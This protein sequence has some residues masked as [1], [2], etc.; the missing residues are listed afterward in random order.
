[1]ESKLVSLPQEMARREKIEKSAGVDGTTSLA[2]QIFQG[3]AAVFEHEEIVTFRYVTPEWNVSHD[4][5]AELFGVTRELFGRSHIPNFNTEV[6]RKYLLK[7]RNAHYEYRDDFHMGD[8]ILI[9]MFVAEVNQASFVLKAEF[10]N[11]ETGKVHATGQQK[12]VYAKMDG[13]ADRI[14]SDFKALLMY[15]LDTNP[16]A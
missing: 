5:Y 10:I 4:K 7:T 16:K 3:L 1:M 2:P 12:I 14:P 8:T 15:L 9:Q 13:K 6:G 11:K